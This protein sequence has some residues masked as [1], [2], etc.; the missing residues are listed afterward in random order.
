M[1]YG[2]QTLQ[3]EGVYHSHLDSDGKRP[4]SLFLPQAYE[5]RYPYPL[6]VFLHGHGETETQWIDSVPAISRRNYIGLGLRGAH[7]VTRQDGSPG[8]GWGRHR[9][10]DGLLEDY[11]LTAIRETMRVCHV[12]SERIY[13]AGFCEG[14]TIAY[15][16]GI[17]FPDKFAGVV[18]LNGWLPNGPLPL[19]QFL[20]RQTLKVFI[21]HGMINP[22]VSPGCAEKAHKIL[23]SAGLPVTLRYYSA[24]HRLQPDMLRDVDRWIIEQCDD[25][26]E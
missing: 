20:R 11:I 6:L 2:T 22:T 8:Y 23:H 25:H 13:L 7:P 18:A 19:G 26:L 10:C 24:G 9:R 21:G 5:P 17:S 1:V 16:M 4:V 3:Q 12:H 15:Q 14:A